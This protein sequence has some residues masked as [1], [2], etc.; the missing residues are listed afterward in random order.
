M[1]PAAR[2]PLPAAPR[3]APPPA[4]AQATAPAGSGLRLLFPPPGAALASNHP[5]TVR[6]M[7]GRRPMTFLVDDAPLPAVPAQ[8]QTAWVPAGSGFYAVTVL[9]ADGLT[10]RAE[11]RLE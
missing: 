2:C 9:D 7:G 3:A 4:A 1:L 6:A 10:V 11:V 8:R 5:V